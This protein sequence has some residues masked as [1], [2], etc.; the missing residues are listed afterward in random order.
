MIIVSEENFNGDQEDALEDPLEP[1][2]V[3]GNGKNKSPMYPQVQE[4]G[5]L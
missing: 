1:E 3:K 4:Q 5:M 2:D